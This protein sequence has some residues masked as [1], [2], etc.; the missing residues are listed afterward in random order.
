[1]SA[2]NAMFLIVGPPAVGKSTTSRAVAARFPRSIHAPVDDFRHMVV[3]GL[4]L[5]GPVWSGE[6]MQQITLARATVTDMAVRYHQAGFAVVIDDFW[7]ARLASDY[8]VLFQHPALQSII[9]YPDQDEAHKRNAERSGDTPARG[10]IDDGIRDVYRHL[11]PA[12]P[13]LKQAGWL[14][15]DTTTMTVEA[16]VNAILLRRSD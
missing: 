7:D 8:G 15:V 2:L 14:I 16:A 9:L 3:S 6:L 1:M 5:P 11:T 10:Y 12:I 13:Q 4:A